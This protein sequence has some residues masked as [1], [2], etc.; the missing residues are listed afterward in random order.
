MI[1]KDSLDRTVEYKLPQRIISLVP[2][3]SELLHDLGLEKR[4]VGITNYC[5]HPYHYQS[6]KTKVG[7]TQKIKFEVIQELQPDFILCSKRGKHS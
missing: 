1:Y 4:I 5:V 3:L 7:G 2:S 6:V